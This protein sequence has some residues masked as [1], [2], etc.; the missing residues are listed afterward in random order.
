MPIESESDD[1]PSAQRSIQR[2]VPI[3]AAHHPQSTADN[4][5]DFFLGTDED[6]ADLVI[7]IMNPQPRLLLADPTPGTIVMTPPADPQPQNL[8]I[9]PAVDD[10]VALSDDTT[11]IDVNSSI[12]DEEFDNIPF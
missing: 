2:L 10:A 9:T 11:A 7:G 12:V 1:V 3:P 8:Q 5:Q 4:W 6:I